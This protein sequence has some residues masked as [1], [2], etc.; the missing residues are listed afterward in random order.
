[1]QEK[2]ERREQ[3][4]QAVLDLLEESNYD[5]QLNQSRCVAKVRVTQQIARGAAIAGLEEV[6]SGRVQKTFVERGQKVKAG[7]AILQVNRKAPRSF[8]DFTELLVAGAR[9]LY[10]IRSGSAPEIVARLIDAGTA[11]R[12]NDGGC[13]PAGRFLIGSLA[14]DARHG[15]ECLHRLEHDGAAT[16]IDDDLTLSNGL[17]WSP[18]G[19][20]MYN[21]DTVP[22]IIWARPYDAGSGACGERTV[23]LQLDGEGA[24]DGLCVDCDGNLWVAVWGAGEVRCYSPSGE[25]RATVSVPAP[26]TSSVAFVG[27]D[28]DALLITTAR[29]QLSS[30]KLDASPLSG[31]LFIADV[32]A[33]GAPVAPWAGLRR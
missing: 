4:D 11:S 31:H 33:R 22:G 27:R 29:E 26:H 30:A 24:P 10:L 16:V 1:M 25:R 21:V 19:T 7:D 6:L 13:D 3:T 28:R 14:L 9:N 2:R 32:Q 5:W 20:V 15:Q 12:L 23:L 8:I 17:A 18:N